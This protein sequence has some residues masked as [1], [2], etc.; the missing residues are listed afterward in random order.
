M[1]VGSHSD[2]K[3]AIE[4]LR[5]LDISF[6]GKSGSCKPYFKVFEPAELRAKNAEI[7]W[8]H[9]HLYSI[10]KGHMEIT[11]LVLDS[12]KRNSV[13]Y[14]NNT[15]VARFVCIDEPAQH[16]RGMIDRKK[17]VFTILKQE[18]EDALK[19]LGARADVE[20]ISTAFNNRRV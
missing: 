18:M 3:Q 8:L 11:R 5:A 20:Q 19:S 15:I 1:R 17:H 10:L 2:R 4:G 16:V 9:T 14:M 6:S 7:R 13:L 12:D